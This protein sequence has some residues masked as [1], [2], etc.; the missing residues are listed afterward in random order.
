MKVED[1]SLSFDDGEI[2][3]WFTMN[4]KH[5]PVH[6]GESKKDAANKAIADANE[7]KKNKQI[8]ENKKQADKLNSAAK[9]PV[10]VSAKKVKEVLSDL[11][12][13]SE[14]AIKDYDNSLNP[15]YKNSKW[16][17][18]PDLKE[19]IGKEFANEYK[20]T[21][22]AISSE[23]KAKIKEAFEH[24]KRQAK[25]YGKAWY[26]E[27]LGYE[28]SGY[29]YETETYVTFANACAKALGVNPVKTSD[30]YERRLH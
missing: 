23:N 29:E 6:K 4:G 8:A 7:S 2:V 16:Y 22:D 24:C 19:A 18:K 14:K 13:F 10:G 15:D 12:K 21:Y 26:D 25:E 27:D 17:K 11:D 20:E 9:K 30:Y 3:G 1:E 5:V 28:R